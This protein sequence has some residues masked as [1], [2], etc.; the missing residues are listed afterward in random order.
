MPREVLEIQN[1][2]ACSIWGKV[3]EICAYMYILRPGPAPYGPCVAK[4][5]LHVQIFENRSFCIFALN[6][7]WGMRNCSKTDLQVIIVYQKLHL[8]KVTQEKIR[9][10]KIARI[11]VL[12][13]SA[14]P[15]CSLY[16]IVPRTYIYQIIYQILQTLKVGKH[17]EIVPWSPKRHK[18]PTLSRVLLDPRWKSIYLGR[19]YE[20]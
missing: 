15:W 5:C 14:V 3:C 1:C 18:V 12:H 11:R 7:I 16:R 13:C 20:E 6:W 9:H 10:Q 2:Q 8:A 17:V 4:T 19:K